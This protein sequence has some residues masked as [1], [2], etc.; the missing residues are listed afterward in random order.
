MLKLFNLEDE[1][2]KVLYTPPQ[3]LPFYY[4][5]IIQPINDFLIILILAIEY[6]N[7]KLGSDEY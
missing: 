5:I 6:A 2:E 7:I 3:K 4:R 1:V